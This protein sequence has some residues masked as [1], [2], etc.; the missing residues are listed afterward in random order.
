MANG[1]V[2]KHYFSL[3]GAVLLGAIFRFWYLDLKPLW[4][5]EVITAIFSLGKNYADLPLNTVFPLNAVSEIFTFVPGITC[6][7]IAENLASQS[8]HPPL[9]F[10]MMYKW[11]GWLHPWGAE[12]VTKVRSLPVIFGITTIL[13]IYALNRLA[14]SPKSGIMAAW[15]MAVSPFAVYLS[16]EARHYT[17]PMLLITLALVG[18]IQIQQDISTRSKIRLWVWLIWGIINIIGLYIHYFFIIAFIAQILTISLLLYQT[19]SKIINQRRVI[20][21]LVLSTTAIIISFIPWLSVIFSHFRSSDTSWLPTTNHIAPIYQTLMNWVL[22]IVIFPVENPSLV[23]AIC[24]GLLMLIFTIWVTWQILPPLKFLW[25]ENKTNLPI[26]TLL[27]FTGFVLLQFLFIAYILGKD[28][29]IIPR[30]SFVYYPSFCVL[31]A[32]SFTRNKNL[33]LKRINSIYIFLLVGLISCVFVVSNLAFQKPFQ[34]EQV[35][36]NLNLEPTKPLMLVIGYDNYQEVAAG[37][38][39]ALALDQVRNNNMDSLAF[40]NKPPSFDLLKNKLSQISTPNVSQLNLWIVG[41]SMIRKDFSPQLQLSQQMTCNIDINQHYR[42]GR[43]PYQ[44]YRCQSLKSFW[45][46]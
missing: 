36:K 10:C 2:D 24:S 35:A 25:L 39:F 30:Y 42:I 44:L 21:E 38:S 7:Q 17:L 41:A 15:I 28:I 5:D 12:W 8:T 33:F 29:T 37:L 32:A 20:L 27:S 18:L 9:F 3:F 46:L 13:A 34:P 19:K 31:L 1:R 4:M 23:I 45:E 26:F 16:Q 11:L 22:M 14:F 43:F 6:S 40:I